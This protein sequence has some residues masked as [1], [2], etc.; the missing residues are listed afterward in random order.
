MRLVFML[1]AAVPLVLVGRVAAEPTSCGLEEVP[2]GQQMQCAPWTTYNE[3]GE[4]VG[5]AR[6]ATA[7][8]AG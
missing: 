2:A 5:G 6:Q 7:G 1:A 8:R 4:I 3:D